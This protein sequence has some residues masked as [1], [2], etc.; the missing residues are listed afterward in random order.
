MKG[1]HLKWKKGTKENKKLQ[2]KGAVGHKQVGRKA[3][4]GQ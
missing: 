4:I 1:T 2:E 3:D